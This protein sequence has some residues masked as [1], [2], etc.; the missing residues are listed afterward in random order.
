MIYSDHGADSLL[1]FDFSKTDAEH[2]EAIAC[3]KEICASSQVPV[4]V[5]GNVKRPEDVKKLIY[6][7][8]AQ[9]LLNGGKPENMR[10]LEEVSKRFGK[11][12]IGV[13]IA[14]TDEYT[15]NRDIIEQYA[16]RLVLLDN[17]E[18][19]IAPMTKLRVLLHVNH[20]GEK[21]VLDLLSSGN[22][23]GI[24]GGFV[25]QRN[26]DLSQVKVRAIERGIE[27]NI[28]TSSIDWSEMKTDANGL[29]PVIVQDYKNDEVLM[30]AYMNEM[31]FRKTLETGKMT[32]FSRRGRDERTFP[33]YKGAEDR[34]R[35]RYDPCQSGPDRSC[36]PHRQPQLLL[37][38]SCEDILRRH[39][40]SSR[41]SGCL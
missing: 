24:S 4:I 7:G 14:D 32:Y 26:L 17:I 13:T 39:K 27:M 12:K 10:F 15:N 5:A 18:K 34:L 31:S 35:Q 11:D 21:Q 33:V 9:A 6:A 1:V 23:T 16:S 20:A 30:L 38:V 19:E 29:V 3:I 25:S 40:S 28:L 2:D 37:Q 22:I 41:I 36:M 8:A